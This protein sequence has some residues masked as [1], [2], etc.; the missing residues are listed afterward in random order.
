MKKKTKILSSI[1]A[2]LMSIGLMQTTLISTYAEETNTKIAT[3]DEVYYEDYPDDDYVEEYIK[4]IEVTKLPNKTEYLVGID[5]E[6]D[7]TGLELTITS[8]DGS[9][10]VYTH[11]GDLNWMDDETKWWFDST[12]IS[13]YIEVSPSDINDIVVG[14]NTF[15]ITYGEKT[16]DFT[17][18]GVDSPVESIEITKSPD[19]ATFIIGYYNCLDYSV[20]LKVNYK[21]GTT[22]FVTYTDT[23]DDVVT[24][25]N[26]ITVDYM[27]CTDEF[28]IFA[29]EVTITKI[30]ITKLPDKVFNTSVTQELINSYAE[31]IRIPDDFYN[32]AI[33]RNMSGAELTVY[34]ENGETDIF[35][36][37]APNTANP[38][39]FHREYHDIYG[40]SVAI[41]DLG[42]YQAK[43]YFRGFTT[44]FTVN[45]NYKPNT[46]TNSN[47][48]SVSTDCEV[49]QNKTENNTNNAIK[50]GNNSHL[51]V[52]LSISLISAGIFLFFNRARYFNK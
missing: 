18:T 46:L 27:G 49:T 24:G 20:E 39:P 43:A 5:T 48:I 15:T 36:F 40:N 35:E 41:Q 12:Y 37:N 17:L 42:N 51:I 28:S 26:T 13:N 21:D 30:E 52:I 4:S 22:E 10:D 2:I 44:T 8:Y 6:F 47:D 31:G 19:N 16:I 29:K 11:T 32:Y 7:F 1:I 25:E 34:F 33:N 38:T 14:D 50:T 3:S 9:T 23:I 45:S